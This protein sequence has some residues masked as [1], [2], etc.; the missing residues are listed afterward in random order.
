[1]PNLASAPR[2]LFYGITVLPLPGWGYPMSRKGISGGL[3]AGRN[4][5]RNSY[6]DKELEIQDNTIACWIPFKGTFFEDGNI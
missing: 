3:D 4:K 1:V 6:T 2:L 5:L